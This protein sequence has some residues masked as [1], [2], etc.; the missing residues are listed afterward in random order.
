VTDKSLVLL[1]EDMLEC[2]D[3]VENAIG[4]LKRQI[5]KNFG[6]KNWNP[7]KI[8][9]VE[10]KGKSGVY[11][12]YPA[13]GQKAEATEDYKNMLRDLKAHNGR[14][15]RN[16]CFVTRQLS[17]ER[18]G[19]NVLDGTLPGCICN[20]GRPLAPNRCGAC[21]VREMCRNASRL[22]RGCP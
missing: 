4:R 9:W 19:V 15:T 21:C 6:A 17:A 13:E 16:G 8:N 10:V 1:A 5:D 18:G 7:E 12:K 11:Q 22:E 2:L 20:F 3:A 14:L